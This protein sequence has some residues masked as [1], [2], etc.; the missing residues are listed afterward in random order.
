MET[1]HLLHALLPTDGLSLLHV[2]L[3]SSSWPSSAAAPPPMA[4]RPGPPSGTW[5]TWFGSSCFRSSI[6]SVEPCSVT[7]LDRA[8]LQLL[9]LAIATL[10]ASLLLPSRWLVDAAALLLALAKGRVIVLDF[11]GLRDAPALWRGCSPR[12][13]GSRC[14]CRARGR[15][16]RTHMIGHRRAR[17]AP[18]KS[19]LGI[20]GRLLS[21]HRT[22]PNGKGRVMAER[23][24]KSAAAERLLRRF[25]LLLC[26]LPRAHS[27]QPLLHG[28]D[29]D[30][31]VDAVRRVARGKHVWEKNSCIN[32]HT[33]LGERLFRARGRQCL[34]PLGG[35]QDPAA[36]REMLKSW[37]Q[38]QPSALPAAGRCRSSFVD[39]ELNDLRRLPAMGR[40]DQASG[41]A[42]EQ[43]RLSRHP[44]P[45]HERDPR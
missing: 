27:A 4:S 8:W 36:A 5:S 9:A 45:R 33:L 11:L 25:G 30:Q 22:S 13:C 17:C 43:G 1:S 42:A 20:A 15:D 12:G 34:G 24:T 37:M 40:H 23:L 18:T 41:L 19:P 28:H 44:A 6:W 26:D 21:H 35:R 2:L 31:C 3:A 38:S 16:P 32:C 29:L 14:A 10:A 7:V 39:Q